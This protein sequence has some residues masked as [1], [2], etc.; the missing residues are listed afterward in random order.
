MK[1]GRAPDRSRVRQ[2]PLQNNV[3]QVLQAFLGAQTVCAGWSAVS[4]TAVAMCPRQLLVLVDE[5]P[6][7]IHLG[8]IHLSDLQHSDLGPGPAHAVLLQSEPSFQ[9]QQ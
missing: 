8:S 4:N 1:L 3:W 9:P 7:S 6:Q 5:L 2:R